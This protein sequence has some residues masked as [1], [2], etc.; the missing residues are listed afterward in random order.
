MFNIIT[1]LFILIQLL[2]KFPTSDWINSMDTADIDSDGVQE[3][4]IG[5]MD[6]TLYCIKFSP[7]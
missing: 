5:C 7:P 4:V 1:V 2:D 3:A 6:S